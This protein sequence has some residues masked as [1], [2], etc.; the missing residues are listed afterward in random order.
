MHTKP[1]QF[2]FKKK[3]GTDMCI[4]TFKELVLKYYTLLK[5]NCTIDISIFL[6]IIMLIRYGKLYMFFGIVLSLNVVYN[7]VRQG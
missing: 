3:H 4:Y 2:G 5:K 7:A 1:N 6:V